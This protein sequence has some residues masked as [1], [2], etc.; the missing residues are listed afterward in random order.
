MIPKES[1]HFSGALLATRCIVTI[2]DY[3]AL[4]L[5]IHVGPFRLAVRSSQTLGEGREGDSDVVSCRSLGEQEDLVFTCEA[6]LLG[7]ECHVVSPA[8]FQRMTLFCPD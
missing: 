3:R 8:A 6:I 5:R 1:R 7:A 4:G 2:R